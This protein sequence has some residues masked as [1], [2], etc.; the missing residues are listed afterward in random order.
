MNVKAKAR[1]V[2]KGYSQI[3]GV[4]F[5][6]LFAPTASTS[7]IRLLVALATMSDHKLSHLD[8]EQIFAQSPLDEDIFMKLPVG[9][10]DSGGTA[11]LSKSLCGLKQASR[12]WNAKMVKDLKDCGFDQC[13][14]DPCVPRL[15]DSKV[16][17]ILL[18]VHVDD[19]L[20]VCSEEDC[21]K[22]A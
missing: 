10:G 6:E 4:D 18:A 13:T 1:L 12:C 3:A 14:A 11:K 21:E 9:R 8:V 22:S 19:I 7:T 5:N 15:M 20:V 17:K 2:L 16:V